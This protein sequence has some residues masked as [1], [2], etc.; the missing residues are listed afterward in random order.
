MNSE[1]PET[2]Y[3]C[4]GRGSVSIYHL[5]SD[6]RGFSRCSEV[7]GHPMEKA[8]RNGWEI[9]RYCSG[10]FTPAG[11]QKDESTVKAEQLLKSMG[12][13]IPPQD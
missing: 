2:V 11:K 1:D 6:C 8:K 13:S 10:K 5:E 12:I 9:C 7:V 3:V 4:N